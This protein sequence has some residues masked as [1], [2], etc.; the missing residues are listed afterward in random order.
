M[1][2]IDYVKIEVV[3]DGTT[4]AAV[5]ATPIN[6]RLL[7]VHVA[8][9]SGTNATTDVVIATEAHGGLPAQPILT[10]T[11]NATSGWYYPRA[12]VVST[13]AAA[14]TNGFDALP[15]AG[16]VGVD[17]AQSTDTKTIAVTL[18]YEVR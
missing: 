4:G 12:T 5:S 11:N 6:G 1:Q 2:K 18:V 13:A 7:A 14:I 9:A 16:Y 15:L 3:V 17:V 10:L 8:Y